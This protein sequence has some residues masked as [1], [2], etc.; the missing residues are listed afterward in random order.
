MKKA[1][2]IIIFCMIFGCS[3]KVR[4]RSINEK[5]NIT[6]NRYSLLG[7]WN[8]QESSADWT[9]YPKLVFMTDSTML[10]PTRGDTIIHCDYILRNDSLYFYLKHKNSQL[11]GRSKII[12]LTPSFLKLSNIL[13]RDKEIMYYKNKDDY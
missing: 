3:I 5:D 4:N 6:L 11:I 9:F 8:I 13:S 12:E 2:A 10:I 7:N 1:L